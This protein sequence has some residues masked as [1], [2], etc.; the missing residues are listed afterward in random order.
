MN[1]LKQNYVTKEFEYDINDIQRPSGDTIVQ[2]SNTQHAIYTNR[3]LS[4]LISKTNPSGKR[5]IEEET[6]VNSTK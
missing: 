2:N 1:S 3:P 6:H 4:E 5:N